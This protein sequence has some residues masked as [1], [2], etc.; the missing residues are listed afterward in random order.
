MQPGEQHRGQ[1][2][3]DHRASAAN[4]ETDQ[5]HGDGGHEVAAVEAGV[6]EHGGDAEE[7]GI[8]VRDFQIG[9]EE[10]RA[11]VRLP[12][13]DRSECCAETGERDGESTR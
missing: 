3:H 1:R 2:Q 11:G 5:E 9:C 8:R 12:Q 4:P 10:E 13:T 7:R 6:F